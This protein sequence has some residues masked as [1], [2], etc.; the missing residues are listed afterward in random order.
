MRARRSAPAHALELTKSL[1]RAAPDAG[2]SLRL[3][4]FAEAN[5]FSTEALGN[6]GGELLNPDA[7]D[8][9]G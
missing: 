3:E 2:G 1:L 4:E 9:E 6:R 7:G 5:R 8:G